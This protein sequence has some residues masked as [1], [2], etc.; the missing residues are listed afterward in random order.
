MSADVDGLVCTARE[1]LLNSVAYSSLLSRPSGSSRKAIP[2]AIPEAIPGTIPGAVPEAI[3]EAIPGTILGTIPGAIPEAIPEAIPRRTVKS[4]G[5]WSV[6]GR[7]AKESLHL[8]SFEDAALVAAAMH[9][10][11]RDTGRQASSRA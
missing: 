4:E 3:P 7:R 2:E 8:F 1:L 5:F 11:N 9:A 10:H 6:F